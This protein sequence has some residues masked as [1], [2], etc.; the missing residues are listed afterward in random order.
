MGR[1]R[2]LHSKVDVVVQAVYVS[3]VSLPRHRQ[4]TLAAFLLT[5][6][7]LRCPEPGCEETFKKAADYFAHINAHNV[8]ASLPL[9]RA[10][11]CLHAHAPRAFVP[12][13]G[14]PCR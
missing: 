1:F 4:L 6:R 3:P 13:F 7:S 14:R 12:R 8:R 9:G 2:A 11:G 5:R 10:H